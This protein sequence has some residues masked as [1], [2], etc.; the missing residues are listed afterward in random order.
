MPVIN[1]TPG[2]DTL[3]G[4]A[5]ADTIS[6]GEGGDTLNAGAGADVLYGFGATDAT[7]G[8]GMIT[9][10]LIESGL[11]RPVFAMSPPG[12][13]DRLFVIEQHT[14]MIKILD[15]ETG[16]V[17]ATPFLDINGIATGNEQGLLGLAFHPDY[18]SNGLYY[19][20]LTN[21]AGDV[22]IWQY[23]RGANPDVSSTTRQLVLAFDHPAETNHNGGWM[24]FGPDGYLYIA[25]GDG[26]GG[27][28]PNNF[29]QNV[30]SLLGKILRID[31]N[32]DD[33]PGNA[34]ANYAIPAGN[35][36][37]GINGA[38]EVFAIGLRNPWRSSFDTQTGDLIIGDV[39][40]G[41]LEEVNF[42]PA[43]ALGGRNFG[44][45]VMEG[46]NVFD[47]DRPGNPPPGSPLLTG[48]IHVYGHGSGPTQGFSITGG[49]V[50]R[51]PDPGA[52]GLYIFA[53]FV[54][55]NIWTMHAG[56]GL[57]EDVV[58][59]NLQ[60]QANAGSVN[61]IASFALDGEGR[62]YT[63]GLDGEIHLLTFTAGAGDGIDILNGGVG[64]DQLFGGV[65]DDQLAGGADNDL[66]NGGLGADTMIGGDGNDIY[67]VDNASDVTLEGSPAGGVDTVQSPLTR[68]L[69]ANLENLTLTGAA[70]ITGYGNVLNNVITGNGAANALY[71][72]DGADTLSGG[73]GA[74]TMFGG[75]GDDTYVID[76][77]G[78]IFI[79][80]SPSGGVDTVQTSVTRNLT[81]NIEN[82]A[83]IGVGAITGYGNVLNNTI[84]GNAA[85][86]SLYGFD[87][88][89]TLD[90]GVGADTM[91]GGAGDDSYIVNDAG[92]LFI[93]ASPSG[94]SDTVFTTITRNLT[95]NIENLTLT[96]G[97][98]ITGYGNILN[99][100]VTGNAAH[101]SL[102][103]FDGADTLSGAGGDD[104]LF[105]GNGADILDGAAGND[106]LIGGADADTFVFSTGP[107][108]GNVDAIVGFSVADDTIRLDAS[109]FP[110][111]NAGA[112][113]EAAAFRIG[114]AAADADDRI[115][116]D[117][118]TGQ[119]FYD[120]DGN[121]AGAQVLF[122]TM[123]A[124]LALTNADFIVSGP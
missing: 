31:V 53:D 89:D 78:D 59:R 43:G 34:N 24:S 30:N 75:N 94:G 38:D 10:T 54:S 100:T 29:A 8:S 105:G 82:L 37:I 44:W 87:G 104:I 72:F 123:A 56:E 23:T 27:G 58:R 67:V 95:A 102:Y 7:P 17:N 71:G 18:A 98:S 35:P 61:Q 40:Q 36:Y 97:A 84:T 88:A 1:G 46:T 9:A 49:Y 76:N 117:S 63:I 92:D 5:V 118:A 13:P 85:N 48:P 96:G 33:F 3:N 26:G 32:G 68:N 42:V 51:G 2:R 120:A 80:T 101:N 103:G 65:G 52:Q 107:G 11:S 74:D 28:D 91:Y 124:G 12:E 106:T 73:A 119:L 4:S 47:G 55:G 14:G 41:A 122:A 70:A 19:A 60:I 86:N 25:T 64:D 45:A 77:A 108:A 39:G 93:E 66:L 115:L 109:A 110:A 62:V 50:I 57:A 113:L 20:Y 81:A 121:G 79:E 6:G 114:A 90:G 21:T 16:N 15:L 69:T 83:L 112:P 111:L 22:E 99:N 116:Y